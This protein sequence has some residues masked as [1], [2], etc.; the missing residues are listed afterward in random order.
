LVEWED[1]TLERGASKDS[2]L[3]NWRR[4]IVS[5]IGDSGAD[6]PDEYKREGDLVQ[7]ARNN[8]EL[9]R[10]T[11]FGAWPA[12]FESGDWDNDASEN[13]IEKVVLCFDYAEK[14]FSQ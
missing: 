9:E 12:E 14:V 11:I 13:R 2:E 4:Q 6:V 5:A 10:H 1:I 8:T 3:Y 7:L